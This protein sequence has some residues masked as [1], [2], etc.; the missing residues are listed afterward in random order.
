MYVG[1]LSFRLYYVRRW[2]KFHLYVQKSCCI[3]SLA[4]CGT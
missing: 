4:E 2:V 3:E 1:G